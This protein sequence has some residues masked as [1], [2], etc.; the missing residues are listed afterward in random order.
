MKQVD[1]FAIAS[2]DKAICQKIISHLNSAMTIKIKD[3]GLIT[4]YN[5]V[6]FEQTREYIKIH[7]HTYIQKICKAHGWDTDETPLRTFP[8]PMNS[9]KAYIKQ[10]DDETNDQHIDPEE[11][12]LKKGFLYRQA[13]GDLIYAMVTTRPN[14]CF[15]VIKLI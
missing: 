8:L 3:I 7:S 11:L 2:T 6:D 15:Q 9:E 1:D 14:I 5:E 12:E 13:I 10:L 4:R